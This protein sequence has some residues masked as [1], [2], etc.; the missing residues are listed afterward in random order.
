MELGLNKDM[1]KLNALLS[2]VDSAMT[3]SKYV[4][5]HKKNNVNLMEL[6]Q[7]VIASLNEGNML[8]E[9]DLFKAL[10]NNNFIEARSLFVSILQNQPLQIQ[11]RA[12]REIKRTLSS[13]NEKLETSHKRLNNNSKPDDFVNISDY[14]RTVE[15]VDQSF[16]VSVLAEVQD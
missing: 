15:V 16:I 3:L 12:L 13:L 5:K 9:E 7:R 1:E 6:R 8:E 10:E 2:K 14:I 4:E 11:K